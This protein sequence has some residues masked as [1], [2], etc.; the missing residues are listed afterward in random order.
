MD[1]TN[2]QAFECKGKVSGPAIFN[3][4]RLRKKG[5][6]VAGSAQPSG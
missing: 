1:S 2:P 6:A 4:S 5:V 3:F